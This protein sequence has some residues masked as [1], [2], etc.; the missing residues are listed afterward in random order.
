MN[1]RRDVKTLVNTLINTFCDV[2][3]YKTIVYV[4][5]HGNHIDPNDPPSFKINNKKK[6]N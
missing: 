3:T 2:R 5:K 4:L 6:G 1:I